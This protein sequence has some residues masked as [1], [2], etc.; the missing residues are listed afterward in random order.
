MNDAGMQQ[1]VHGFD[2]ETVWQLAQGDVVDVTHHGVTRR[3]RVA[4]V[5]PK[6]F[7]GVI[8]FNLELTP[9]PAQ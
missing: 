7:F 6:D 8:T 2:W 5:Q 1:T 4:S 3:Y 9:A